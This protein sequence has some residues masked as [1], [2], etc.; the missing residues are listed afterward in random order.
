MK[1]KL[2]VSVAALLAALALY[3]LLFPYAVN[4]DAAVRSEAQKLG[5][6]KDDMVISSGGY[7]S[8]WLSWNSYLRFQSKSHPEYGEIYIKVQKASPF[9]SWV[10]QEYQLHASQGATELDKQ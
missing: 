9:H 6:E 8:K 4:L 3:H 10:V 5:W 7:S 1:K 2:F